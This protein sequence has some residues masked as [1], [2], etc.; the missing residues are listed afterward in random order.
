MAILKGMHRVC[1]CLIHISC[2]LLMHEV[3]RCSTWTLTRPQS[4]TKCFAA[5][6]AA[7]PEHT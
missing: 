3:L 7:A 2:D 5:A 4:L 6:A 1:C